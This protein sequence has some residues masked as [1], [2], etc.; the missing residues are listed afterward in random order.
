MVSANSSGAHLLVLPTRAEGL[1]LA[2]LEAMAEARPSWSATPG[3]IRWIVEGSG[4][5]VVLDDRAPAAVAA[6]IRQLVADGDGLAAMGG[7]HQAALAGH[8]ERA[9]AAGIELLL[10]AVVDRPPGRRRTSAPS[11]DPRGRG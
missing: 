7:G 1:A 9:G 4:C 6:A 11:P 2:M 10:S 3:N 5:G 8:S